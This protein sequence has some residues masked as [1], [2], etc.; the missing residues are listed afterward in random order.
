MIVVGSVDINGSQS[1]F[2]QG[3]DLMD[4]SAPGTG[5]HCTSNSFNDWVKRQGTSFAAL[6]VAGLAACFL[7]SNPNLQGRG[8]VTQKVKDHITSL[9]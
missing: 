6:A 2:S 4:V 7:S 1:S 9:A 3:G 8:L 5:I